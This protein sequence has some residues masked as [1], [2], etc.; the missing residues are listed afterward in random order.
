[1]KEGR[2]VKCF[3]LE[4]ANDDRETRREQT[5]G[6]AI[7]VWRRRRQNGGGLGP[8]NESQ[9]KVGGEAR[10]ESSRARQARRA[11]ILGARSKKKERTR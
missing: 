1:M 2:G 3:E 10:L 6:C 4:A 5:S 9:K 11:G 7:S 8:L